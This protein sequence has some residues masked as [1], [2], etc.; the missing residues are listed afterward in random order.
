MDHFSQIR[1]LFSSPAKDPYRSHRQ[2]RSPPRLRNAQRGRTNGLLLRDRG[3]ESI[4]LQ[5]RVGCQLDAAGWAADFCNIA[6]GRTKIVLIAAKREPDL[7]RRTGMLLA[8]WGSLDTTPS[9]ERCV[10]TAEWGLDSGRSEAV[11]YR[12]R[13]WREMDSNHRYRKDKLPFR[14]P[15]FWHPSGGPDSPEGIT[16]SRPGRR[17]ACHSQVNRTPPYQA[18]CFC[19]GWFL[20]SWKFRNAVG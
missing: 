5:R 4:S 13:R 7:T 20:F 18:R 11:S 12:T 6:G 8:G 2:S 10:S 19:V 3:F 17:G 9:G 15:P 1:P 16:G 14:G